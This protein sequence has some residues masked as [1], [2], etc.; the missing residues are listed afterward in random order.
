MLQKKHN[1]KYNL[2]LTSIKIC[3]VHYFGTYIAE[4]HHFQKNKQSS[5]IKCVHNS[6][7]LFSSSENI[8]VLCVKD[9][10]KLLLSDFWK[11]GLKLKIFFLWPIPKISQIKIVK[12]SVWEAQR[13]P[14][15]MKK[16][17]H[18]ISYSV[19]FQLQHA[20]DGL[21]TT[22]LIERSPW[23]IFNSFLT[24]FNGRT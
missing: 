14:L 7:F 3:S 2:Y 21:Q 11:W 6:Y 15:K 24:C 16:I 10:I 17:R 8:Y 19:K 4:N 5:K 20:L 18:L 1:W 9:W 23:W 12:M 22:Q 13:K